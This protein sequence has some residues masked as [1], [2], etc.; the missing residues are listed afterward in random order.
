MNK[1]RIFIV[2][3]DAIIAMEI[4]SSLQSL[5]YKVTSIVSTSKKVDKEKSGGK[6]GKSRE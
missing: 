4:E 5:G 6:L 1:A 2:E 3:D